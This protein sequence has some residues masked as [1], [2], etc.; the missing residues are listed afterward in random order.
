MFLQNKKFIPY[1]NRLNLRAGDL[2]NDMTEA[3]KKLWF[4]YLRGHRYRFVRQK[5]IGNYILDFYCQKLKLGI[6]IDGDTHLGKSQERYDKNR[7]QELARLGIRVLRFWNYDI[8]N[9]LG[10]VEQIIE[11]NLTPLPPLYKGGERA[12]T[13]PYKGGERAATPLYKGGEIRHYNIGVFGQVQGVGF[14][15]YSQAEAERLGLTG[16]VANRPDGSVYIEAEGAEAELK[17]FAAWCRSGS[18]FAQVSRVEVAKAAVAG[19]TDF[20]I[21]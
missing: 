20:A 17:K 1:N 16:W 19:Y 11:E 8:F 6:E 14:R 21:R 3:E 9:G 15:Y 18:R 4:Q 2:R 5:V 7:T 13:P 10:A 12:A